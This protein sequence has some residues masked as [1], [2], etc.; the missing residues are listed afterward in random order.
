MDVSNTA[1]ASMFT[2]HELRQNND[3][4]LYDN[5]NSRAGDSEIKDNLIAIEQSIEDFLDAEGVHLQSVS[6]CQM[7][8]ANRNFVSVRSMKSKYLNQSSKGRQA[9]SAN[10]AH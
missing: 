9:P 8:H 10:T 3:Q 7:W 4:V 2:T 1:R 5:S 6:D